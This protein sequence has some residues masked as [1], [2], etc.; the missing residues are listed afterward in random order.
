MTTSLRAAE[1]PPMR[2]GLKALSLAAA[3]AVSLALM[4]DP[5]LLS[6]VSE[7]RIH[8]ALPLMMFGTV[9]LFM[10]GLGFAPKTRAMR[11]I[12][13]PVA[14]WLLFLAGAFAL[15]GAA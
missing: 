9:G 13:H 6:G 10:Y 3:G 5:Y 4:V 2:R 15:V 12:F 11:L 8:S 7:P 14:A 1:P